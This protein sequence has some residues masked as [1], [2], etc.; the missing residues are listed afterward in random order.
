[1]INFDKQEVLAK[2]AKL[3][4]C[5][6][7]L[8]EEFVGIDYIIDE[9]I[10][11]LSLWYI[12]PDLL[13]RPII[14]N[15][16]GMTGV[17]K[18]DLVRKLVKFL[19]FQDRFAEVELS[20]TDS[21]GYQNSVTQVLENNG[22][23]DGKPAIILFDE[24]QRFNALNQDGTPVANSR[25]NDFWEL[26][27]DG[28]LSR[29]SKED[30]DFVIFD[31]FANKRKNEQARLRGEDVPAND[32]TLSSW[33]ALEL[34]K[35]LGL[36][37]SLSE[38][39]EIN[40]EQKIELI[41]QAKAKKQIYEPVDHSKTLIIISGN[42]DD[43]FR[44]AGQTSDADV[45]ADIYRAYTEKITLVDIK[46]ALSRR[47]RPEQVAR[48]GN[49][50]LIYNSLR[51][52]EF[53]QL[54]KKEIDK[55]RMSILEKFGV[56]ITVSNSV[57]RLVYRNGVFPV[58][59]VRPVFSSIIDI[60]ESNW[61][62]FLFTAMMEG[63]KTIALDYDEE[64]K[65]LIAKI[66]DKVDSLSYS[67]RIDKIR[68]EEKPDQVANISVHEAGH[69]VAYL[70]LTG[71]VPLQL[72]SK[73]ASSYAAGFTFSH[74]IYSTCSG[75]LTQI[76]IY[77]AGGLAEEAVFGEK[78]ASTG[79]SAD[80]ERISELA[81]DY[82]RKFG[83]DPDFQAVYNHQDDRYDMYSRPTDVKVEALIGTQVAATKKLLKDNLPLLLEVSDELRRKGNVDSVKLQTIAQAHG[84]EA[85]M[86]DKGFVYVT[87]YDEQLSKRV[88]G[89]SS[90]E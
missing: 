90:V 63:A 20:N 36:S 16:W 18:T 71:M 47:F 43:A 27:S 51:K 2:K 34:K 87:D 69:A 6:A 31:Y 73:I 70:V 78:H 61:S 52:V 37:M 59:G 88:K 85:R 12:M 13:T 25:F 80:R 4:D 56:E 81:I 66:G 41:M 62:S 32:R 3:A 40:E 33:E 46:N 11:Y 83:F 21:T 49:I 75:I 22:I 44:M 72:K 53:E 5:T 50:H 48:F 1:M 8:K 7:Y 9:V 82:V 79:R 17:G 86:E 10:N 30:L 84:R 26:L 76:S 64:D 54:I 29:K 35:S 60:L 68:Q 58:Q 45:D 74:E 28:R 77:L 57:E 67:G 42:L 65:L 23:T 89:S 55:R 24:I 14:I 38:L 19:E 15:L 39:T